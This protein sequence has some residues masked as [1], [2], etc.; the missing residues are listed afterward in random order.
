MLTLSV[1]CFD[2]LSPRTFI[3]NRANSCFTFS[4]CPFCSKVLTFQHAIFT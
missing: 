3:P 1:Q 2:S 4:T